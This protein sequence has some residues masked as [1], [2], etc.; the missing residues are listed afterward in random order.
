MQSSIYRV[1]KEREQII[2]SMRFAGK[3][4]QEIADYFSVSKERI[5]QLESRA[6]ALIYH[7]QK[8]ER[9]ILSGR[10]NYATSID[11]LKLSARTTNSLYNN[12]VKTIDDLK[13][14]DFR[15]AREEWHGFGSKALQEIAEKLPEG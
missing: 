2:L 13:H 15:K 10:Y 6:W 3:T 7:L 4:L 5:R 9:D 14:V 12:G 11:S 8:Q 1:P